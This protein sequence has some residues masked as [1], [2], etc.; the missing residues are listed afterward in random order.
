ME[1][2]LIEVRDRGTFIPCIAVKLSSL[3]VAEHFLMRRA[4]YAAEQITPSP[5]NDTEPYILFSSLLGGRPLEYDA[6]AWGNRTMTSAHLHLIQ[7]WDEIT[8]GAVVDAEFILGES[9]QP[10]RSEREIR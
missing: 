5:L 6:Y 3:D 1:T 8:T 7:H 4:G 10:K 2:K 9:T